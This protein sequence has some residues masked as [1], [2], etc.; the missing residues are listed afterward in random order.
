MYCVCLIYQVFTEDIWKH[1]R[2]AARM[3]LYILWGE[4]EEA[5]F[6]MQGDYSVL[7]ELTILSIVCIQHTL[8][9]II[10]LQNLILLIDDGALSHSSNCEAIIHI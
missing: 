7:S 9:L 3:R 2:A 5:A 10:V 8:N 1:T 6:F 4:A